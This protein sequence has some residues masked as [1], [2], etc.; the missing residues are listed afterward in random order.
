MILS[1]LVSVQ[2][3]HVDN[4]KMPFYVFV[5]GVQTKVQMTLSRL[6]VQHRIKQINSRNFL[7]VIWFAL[8]M[9]CA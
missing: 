5:N 3:A 8:K 2:D 6:G 9:H 4:I 7:V 1:Q